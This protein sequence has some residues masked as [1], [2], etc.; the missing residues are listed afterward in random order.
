MKKVSKIK[1]S[2][3]SIG[4]WVSVGSPYYPE[5]RNTPLRVI[6]ITPVDTYTHKNSCTINLKDERT[7]KRYEVL[8]PFIAPLPLNEEMLLSLG[9]EKVGTRYLSPENKEHNKIIMY[10][11]SEDGYC[12]FSMN[13]FIEVK[14]QYVHQL[15]NVVKATM[16][17]ELKM[18]KSNDNNTER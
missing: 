18:S 12:Y 17:L 4:N 5:L 13:M 3:L 11:Q 14:M 8:M 2:E 6:G 16:G 9:F 10:L 15:Q 7:K 1:A